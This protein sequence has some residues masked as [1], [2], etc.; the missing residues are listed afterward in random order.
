MPEDAQNHREQAPLSELYT[1]LSSLADPH[2][3]PGAPLAALQDAFGCHSLVLNLRQPDAATQVLSHPPLSHDLLN[4]LVEIL[5]SA[6]PNAAVIDSISTHPDFAVLEAKL[7]QHDIHALVLQPLQHGEQHNGH[8]L[9]NYRQSPSL[10]TEQSHQ[11]QATAAYLAALLI[12]RRQA[13]NAT[14]LV[15]ERERLEL[16]QEIAAFANR[17]EK[18]E[19]VLRFAIDRICAFTRWPLG[20]AFWL[21]DRQGSEL[22]SSGIWHCSLEGEIDDFRTASSSLYIAP[23]DGWLG[24]IAAGESE[25]WRNIS[26]GASAIEF[27]PDSRLKIARD[28]GLISV[29]TV[30]VRANNH[31]YAILEFYAT[32]DAPP[33]AHII[34]ALAFIASQ[35]A[36]VV[37]REE[38]RHALHNSQR[39]LAEAQRLAHLG[40]WEWEVAS[41]RLTWSEELYRIY[42]LDRDTFTPTY[43]GWLE[44]VHLEDRERTNQ[45]VQKAFQEK[46]PF[47][48]YHR[49]VRADGIVR[50]LHAHGYPVLND[51]DQVVR[52]YGSG[53]DVTDRHQTEE[54]LRKSEKSYRTLARNIPDAIVALYDENLKLTLVEGAISPFGTLNLPSD[55]SLKSVLPD[56]EEEDSLQPYYDA[57][58]GHARSF[59]RI[60][61]DH[62]FAIQAL[63]VRDEDGQI[64][65]GIAMAQ[66]IT[67]RKQA[68]QK[69][70]R[71]AQQLTA[72]HEIGQTIAASLDLDVI[73]KRV[74]ETLRPL[75][76]AEGVFVLLVHDEDSLVFA[77]ANEV[78][79]GNLTGQR[80]PATRGVAS[81]VIRSGRLHW[82]QGDETLERVYHELKEVAHYHPRTIIAAP[83][84]LHGR[85]IGV[86]EAVH[87]Q[88]DAFS[89]DDRAIMEAA[90]HWVAI[91]IGNARQHGR[92]QHQLQESEALAEISRA[93]SQTL[94]L[95]RILNLIV[96]SARDL[97]PHAM[98][99]IFYFLNHDG[100]QPRL[101]PAAQA[102]LPE[103]DDNDDSDDPGLPPAAFLNRILETVGKENN[104]ET[105][106][107]IHPQAP[108]TFIAIPVQG[109]EER[110]GVLVVC[111]ATTE[112]FDED[113]SRLL[114][115]LARQAAMAVENARL[116]RDQQHARRTAD[117]LRAANV[118]LSQSLQLRT[119]L[120]TLLQYANDLIGYDDAVVL[121]AQQNN[122]LRIELAT[123]QPDAEGASLAHQEYPALMDALIGRMPQIWLPETSTQLL[124]P[125]EIDPGVRSWLL[126][127][128]LSGD[129]L[130]GLLLLG[131]D[132]EKAYNHRQAV[133]AQGLAAQATIA[134]HNARLFSEVETSRGRLRLLSRQV[135]NAQ[136]EE[137]QRIS[138]E[139]HDEAGQA[140]TALKI[141]LEMLRAAWPDLPD[142]L[143]EQLGEA[144]EMTDGTMEQIRLLAHDLRPP[145]LDT[146]GLAT[147]I[148]GLARDFGRRTRLE[149]SLQ[150]DTLP[151]LSDAVT[152]SFYRFVQEALTNIA[153]HAQAAQVTIELRHD[154][155]KIM[156]RVADDGK[157]F[158]ADLLHQAPQ[159]RSGIGLMGMQDRFELLSGWI[160][161]HTAPEQ[162]T[163]VSAYV[164]YRE[165]Q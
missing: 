148:E 88:P 92:L 11:L 49:I 79:V 40:S 34:D 80:V 94:D 103:I 1:A 142:P 17:T 6:S 39:L 120:R 96:N 9:L 114:T 158:D 48:Y 50:V 102:G 151:A 123:H 43:E 164:P 3:P 67:E 24:A 116:F 36:R 118:A 98:S 52:M 62:T 117:T 21:E 111:S 42:G 38:T 7:G 107:I 127:P 156:V 70:I 161:I 44:Y 133:L 8:L 71:R 68:E 41:N 54:A 14:T 140:L 58:A 90:A 138:R 131:S 46:Q 29:F 59:E 27:D 150:A 74:L 78:G 104:G 122:R 16:L 106:P 22:V 130:L 141:S 165:D 115:L 109:R 60:Y 93:L 23:G 157:G 35:L 89:E 145:V 153:R 119:V 144:I 45:I 65:A 72:L 105:G 160:E 110:V 99:S 83:M 85:L 12:A 31:S 146:F 129:N 97:M 55:A 137:R 77:A 81:D 10:S 101:S 15:R 132:N 13:A 28:L 64:F 126:I 87:S 152:I 135:V 25:G 2:Q 56:A 82:L 30:P 4:A 125:P 66:D 19:D 91:A 26:S 18:F 84:M 100:S 139:L 154:D 76:R 32:E 95:E 134:I 75:V 149:I 53:Q 57:L 73:F 108:H 162:G 147:S 86:M 113:D 20:H 163:T 155:D 121:L 128:L 37:S 69:V 136:E 63:P 61:N 5:D 33:P 143:D 51:D 47:D 112:A 124:L 159:E